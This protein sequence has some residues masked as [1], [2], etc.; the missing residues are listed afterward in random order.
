[1]KK[2]RL[3]MGLLAVIGMSSTFASTSSEY[4]IANGLSPIEKDQSISVLQPFQGNFRILG[5]KV[6]QNDEQ[7]K[8]SPIDYAVSWGLFA[9]PEIARHISV[10][11]YDRYLNWKI[12]KL[13][14]PAEQAMQMV[15]NMHIIPAN[16]EIAQ[17]IKQVKR[18]DL[19][20]LKGDLVEIKDKNLVW[21]SSLTPTD[22]GDGACE[23]FRVQAI[24]WV[25][26]QN[27]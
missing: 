26:K 7:A 1:M 17:Q 15:S 6:Y 20:Y 18:G 21:K 25:E 2:Q 5:S 27:I 11:Q 3:M 12:P 9:Q 23:L 14:V 8:F 22:T 16:P 19:V 13:P 10:K 4:N 24:H